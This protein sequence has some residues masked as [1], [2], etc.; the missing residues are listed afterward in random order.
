MRAPAQDNGVS[1]KAYGRDDR[2][3]A[4][5]CDRGRA[6]ESVSSAAGGAAQPSRPRAEAARLTDKA[7]VKRF[8]WWDY[9]V[10]AGT[11]YTTSSAAEREHRA[12]FNRAAAA[13]QAF[14]REC[15]KGALERLP[16][17][18]PIGA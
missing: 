15:P 18:S 7:P 10:Y 4:R 2:R 5:V 12:L 16:F 1:V 11:P 14:R 8:H 9:R 13:S 17:A 6:R 3:F